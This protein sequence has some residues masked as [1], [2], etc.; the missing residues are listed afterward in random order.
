MRRYT[1]ENI[2]EFVTAPRFDER[3]LLDRDPS[4]PSISIVVPSFNQ[5]DFL[6]RT[7]LSVLNQNYR[8]LELV[9]IDG[10][11]TDN[12]G[13]I[14]KKYERYISHWVSEP[15]EG[16]YD[17]INKGFRAAT[18]QLVGWQ[19]S[20]DLYLPGALE[21]VASTYEKKGEKEVFFGNTYLIDGDDTILKDMRFIPFS[22]EHLIHYDWNLSSQAVFWKR[23]LFD[24]AG[25][26]E[27]AYPVL[28]D[29]DWFIR[30]GKRNCR[31]MFIR[32][33]L[34]A[35]RIHEA[36][37]LSIVSLEERKPIKNKILM[38]YNIKSHD[39]FQLSLIKCKVFLRRVIWYLLQ[40]DFSYLL[41]GIWRR[42]ARPK[43]H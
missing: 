3:A 27:D 19:N 8:N 33:F 24:A 25:Y 21:I 41:G 26:L 15:D 40:G 7:I 6:E 37:K 11:S 34:G 32:E 23:E 18:G 43:T 5:G 31:Y 16:Q 28:G 20:D 1:S 9:V 29:W 39:T 22:V 36:A 12:S 38:R 30:L 17:A 35:Y 10:G 13:E 42:I 2:R 14:I 4:R